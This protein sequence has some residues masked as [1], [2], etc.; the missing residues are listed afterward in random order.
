MHEL[1]ICDALL[2]MVDGVVKDEKLEGVTKITVEVGML[3]GVMPA[4]LS[5]CWVAVSDGTAYADT[6]FVVESIPGT[7]ECLDCGAVFEADLEKLVCPEC[8]GHKLN[9][10]TGREL[11]IKE[12]EAY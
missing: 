1:G 2:K 3:S 10:L 9:P 12:I 8:S 11:T 6:E 5:D 7:A 4:F